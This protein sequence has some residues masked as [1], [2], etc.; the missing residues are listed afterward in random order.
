MTEDK[1]LWTA[2]YAEGDLNEAESLAYEDQLRHDEELKEYLLHYHDA[3]GSLR[4]FM[5][6]DDGRNALVAT[7]E[8][9]NQ[10]HF[11][12]EPQIEENIVGQQ[13]KVLKLSAYLRW[14]SV[15]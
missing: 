15:A 14:V 11:G 6:Y 5:G 9:L 10:E 12:D 2:R 3:H 13:P 7:L 1:I 4:M 8:K